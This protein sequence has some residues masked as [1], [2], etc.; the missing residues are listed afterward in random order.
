MFNKAALFS[1]K[2]DKDIKKQFAQSGKKKSYI[3]HDICNT[4]S[5]SI[6][7]KECKNCFK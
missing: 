1:S 4:G 5:M 6:K 7:Y 2:E 3:T